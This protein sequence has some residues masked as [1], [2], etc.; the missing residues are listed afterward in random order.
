MSSVPHPVALYGAVAEAAPIA[1]IVNGA[2]FG[3]RV[4]LSAVEFVLPA[5]KLTQPPW[6]YPIRMHAYSLISHLIYGGRDRAG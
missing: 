1:K 5:L 6:R 3:A 2:G 4:W